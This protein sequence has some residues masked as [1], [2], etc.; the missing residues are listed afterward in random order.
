MYF[1]RDNW[2]SHCGGCSLRH[3]IKHSVWR[4]RMKAAGLKHWS[5]CAQGPKCWPLPCFGEAIR[6]PPRSHSA[7]LEAACALGQGRGPSPFEIPQS[8]TSLSN[9]GDVAVAS[10]CSL[11]TEAF[12][13]QDTKNMSFFYILPPFSFFPWKLKSACEVLLIKCCWME[14]QTPHTGKAF[15]EMRAF[16]M[17]LVVRVV[18][19]RTAPLDLLGSEYS[20]ESVAGK[21]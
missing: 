15:E 13:P 6:P 3:V 1:I 12:K 2:I 14:T 18:W 7:R 11:E 5:L 8:Q 4:L 9:G 17:C 10:G 20:R 21:E 16:L 19:G